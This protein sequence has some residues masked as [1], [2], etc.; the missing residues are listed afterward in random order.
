MKILIII[1]LNNR[2]KLGKVEKVG[3]LLKCGGKDC[4]QISVNQKLPLR[5]Q[6]GACPHKSSITVTQKGR[7]FLV[8]GP[9]H[10]LSYKDDA[11]DWMVLFQVLMR[12]AYKICC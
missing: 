4:G 11:L 8:P 1:M 5:K 2:C 7:S 6:C 3:T 12:N 10:F 9:Y